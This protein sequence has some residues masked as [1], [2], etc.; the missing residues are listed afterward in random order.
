VIA[1]ETLGIPCVRRGGRRRN[2]D[3]LY[4][5]ILPPE[6]TLDD[7]RRWGECGSTVRLLHMCGVRV[8]RVCVGCQTRERPR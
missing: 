3:D 8:E 7:V 5:L 2:R 4:H 1:T 6:W